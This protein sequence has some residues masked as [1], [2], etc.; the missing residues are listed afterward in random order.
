[1]QRYEVK[2][3]DV[4]ESV[5][6]QVLDAFLA[7]GRLI[8]NGGKFGGAQTFEL[9][10]Y[11]LS[12]SKRDL[13]SHVLRFAGVEWASGKQYAAVV[14]DPSSTEAPIKLT[15]LEEGETFPES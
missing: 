9:S 2:L 1:M 7:N 3:Q 4:S 6:R 15:V 10:V 8:A 13:V 5:D 14:N 11:E 12:G